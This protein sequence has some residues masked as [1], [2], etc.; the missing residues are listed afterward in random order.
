VHECLVLG[1]VTGC[2]VLL[3]G[4]ARSLDEFFLAIGVVGLLSIWFIARTNAFVLLNTPADLRGTVMGIWTLAMPGLYPVTGLVVGVVSTQIGP[5]AG[6]AIGGPVIWAVLLAH[7]VGGRRRPA[8][9]SG[10]VDPQGLC[11]STASGGA[12]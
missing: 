2:A 12:T 8:R 9:R 4:L 1:F 10:S 11:S 7:W 3:T 6:Y 5:R